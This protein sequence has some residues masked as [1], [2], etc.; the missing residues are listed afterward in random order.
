MPDEILTLVGWRCSQRRRGSVW[1]LQARARDCC[2]IG[3]AVLAFALPGEALT[4]NYSVDIPSPTGQTASADFSFVNA[5]TLQI[6][7][8][9]TTPAGDSTVTA[10]SAILA[11]IAFKLPDTAVIAGTGDGAAGTRR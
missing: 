8:T 7:L 9:E 11:A 1:L 3:V 5:T 4:V 6:I 2:S 10:G